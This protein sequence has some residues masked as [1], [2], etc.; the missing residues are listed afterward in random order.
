MSWFS[1]TSILF[2]LFLHLPPF[3]RP[4]SFFLPSNHF[5]TPTLYIKHPPSTFRA[6]FYPVLNSTQQ[7]GHQGGTRTQ[8]LVLDNP[9]LSSSNCPRDPSLMWPTLEQPDRNV[10][11]IARHLLVQITDITHQQ[12]WFHGT[13]RTKTTRLKTVHY[14]DKNHPNHCALSPQYI[15]QSVELLLTNL[16]ISKMFMKAIRQADFKLHCRWPNTLLGSSPTKV[17]WLDFKIASNT[18]A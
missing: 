4:A 16:S 1:F 15:W 8:S 18:A 6:L 17:F 5:F 14:K 12:L 7:A 10:F 3:C 13:L 9:L 11:A 2:F